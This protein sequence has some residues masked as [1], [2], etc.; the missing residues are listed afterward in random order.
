MRY[1]F[2]RYNYSHLEFEITEEQASLMKG[3]IKNARREA[4]QVKELSNILA[5]A[6]E[7]GIE[8]AIK[9]GNNK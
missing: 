3:F 7:E 2:G 8:E 5:K 9:K 6:V 4:K 1:L